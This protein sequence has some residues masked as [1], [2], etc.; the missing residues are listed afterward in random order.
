MTPIFKLSR[1]GQILQDRLLSL[2][3]TDR[4]GLQGDTLDITCN[5][6]NLQLPP[7]GVSI[8]VELGYE[9]TEIWNLG[10]FI[11]QEYEL[12]GPPTELSIRAISIP[13]SESAEIALQKTAKAR[14]WEKGTTLGTIINDV[15]GDVGL[16][17]LFSGELGNIMLPF[18]EK[19]RESDASFLHRIVSERDGIVKYRGNEVIIEKKDAQKLNTQT[20]DWE[21][22]EEGIEFKLRTNERQRI[23]SV[24]AKYQNATEGK[25]ISVI[26]GNP[27][28]SYLSKHT[29][30]DEAAAIDGANALLKQFERDHVTGIIK[31]PARSGLIAETEIRLQN[32]PGGTLFNRNYIVEVATYHLIPK[33]ALTTKLILRSLS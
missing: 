1:G 13:Q 8:T 21:S 15:V 4:S 32:F 17:T 11:V 3:V 9:E 23:S 16:S 31:L 29:F 20:L 26:V 5:A 12:T 25:T 7:I 27:G 6:E 24:T 33:K 28:P 14:T 2:K 18:T 19:L 30:G 22:A 10:S